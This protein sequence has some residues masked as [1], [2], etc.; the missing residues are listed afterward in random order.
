VRFYEAC[1]DRTQSAE[2]ARQLERIIGE[3]QAHARRL[4]AM[5]DALP[6]G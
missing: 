4:Q 3:E 5:R 2:A 1:R 6:K